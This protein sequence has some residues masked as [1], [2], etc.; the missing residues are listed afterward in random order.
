MTPLLHPTP[1]PDYGDGRDWASWH[2]A[3]R[4]LAYVRW[5]RLG[6]WGWGS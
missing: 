1:A 3:T 5:A 4:L 6:A 2:T